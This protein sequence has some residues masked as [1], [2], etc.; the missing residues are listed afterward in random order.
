M[1][2]RTG[3]I[4]SAFFLLLSV[5]LM[6]P[7]AHTYGQLVAQE[8]LLSHGKNELVSYRIDYPSESS[9][10][11]NLMNLPFLSNTY[12]EEELYIESWMLS[13]FENVSMDEELNVE[14]WMTNPFAADQE[15]EVEEW[16][17]SLWY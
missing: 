1:N 8:N 5:A 9:M 16:M 13:P 10:M 3:I 11:E 2:I 14:S 7:S 4:G 15:S 6:V 17:A 12:L